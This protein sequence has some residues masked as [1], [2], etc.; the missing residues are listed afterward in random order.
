MKRIIVVGDDKIGNSALEA[1]PKN[2]SILCYVDRSTN[3]KRLY[4]LIKKRSISLSLAFKM[5]LCEISRAGQKPSPSIPSI[6]GNQ[7][8]AVEI[9][10]QR[11]QEVI[12]F[13]AGL[14]VNSKVLA[15][16]VKILNIHCTRLPDYG[17]IGTI[18]R[19][20]KDKEYEQAASLHI[21]TEKIDEGFVVSALPYRLDPS[22]SYCENE[23][24][25]Y[26]SGIQLLKGYF[27][28]GKGSTVN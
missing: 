18:A 17:G 15:E 19:A 27:A 9:K 4:K 28:F 6:G 13:R 5:L 8:L 11:P 16:G 7:E 25:A 14:I 20:L 12:L 2:D 3:F 24:I 1:L 23:M 26:K 22:L 21:V 10:K